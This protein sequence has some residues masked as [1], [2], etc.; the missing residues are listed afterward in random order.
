VEIQ[1]TGATITF[2]FV[3][4][5]PSDYLSGKGRIVYMDYEALHPP[6]VLRSVKPGDRIRP[7]GMAGNKKLKSFFIDEK[8]PRRLRESIPLLADRHS[9]LWIAGMRMSERAKIM[10]GTQRVLK[11]EIV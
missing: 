3:E 4:K 9:I 2:Q 6:I 11:I 1:E 8:I 7:L 5:T 10:P